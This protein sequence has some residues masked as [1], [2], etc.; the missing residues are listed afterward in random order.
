[1]TFDRDGIHELS[2]QS[3]LRDRRGDARIPEGPPAPKKQRPLQ[4][5]R[6]DRDMIQA[7]MNAQ[8]NKETAALLGITAHTVK[9]YMSRLYEKLGVKDR[10]D[11][12]RWGR[13]HAEA[14]K[15]ICERYRE[16]HPEA[17]EAKPTLQDAVIAEYDVFKT[18]AQ[19]IS[20]TPQQITEVIEILYTKG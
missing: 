6:R 13:A 10:W 9:V 12:A 17:P 16:Q 15:R 7:V 1:M 5:S 3:I 8:K 20:F 19:S 4:L 2:H 11:L 14:Q 18:M